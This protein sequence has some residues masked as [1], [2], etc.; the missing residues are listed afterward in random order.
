MERSHRTDDEEFYIPFIARI[1]SESGLLRRA[2]G[3]VYFY[4]LVRPHY[5]EGMNEVSPFTKLQDL[6]CNLPET[7]AVFPPLVLDRIGARTGPWRVVT[8]SC[9]TTI[10]LS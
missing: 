7:F 3:W 5:G 2:A 8:I 4:N 1:R 10:S 9:P 6:G